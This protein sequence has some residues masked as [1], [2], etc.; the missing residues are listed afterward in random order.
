MSRTWKVD[1]DQSVCIGSGLCL[2][3]APEH[4]VLDHTHRSRPRQTAIE[5]DQN[6]LDAVLCC[7]VQAIT[8]TDQATG[9]PPA[10]ER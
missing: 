4:F 6:V 10:S 3:T 5:P 8:V 7:P 2:G 9:Q 1:V